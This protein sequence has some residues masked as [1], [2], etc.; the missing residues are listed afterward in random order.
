MHLDICTTQ[1]CAITAAG[2][3]NSLD[4]QVDPCE[5]FYQFACGGFIAKNEIPAGE[6]FISNSF[7]IYEQNSR[8]IREIS[9][10]SLGKAPKPEVGDAAAAGNLKKLHDLFS[11]CM[12]ETALLKAGR[13]PLAD[14]VQ[15]ILDSLP[16]NPSGVDKTAL[17]KTMA[18]MQKSGMGDFVTLFVNP[19]SANPQQN[20]LNMIEGGLGLPEK[21]VYQ[22]RAVLALYQGIIAQMF[23]IVLGD[24]DVG[25]RTEPLMLTD[26][27]QEWLDAAKIVVDFE[28]LLA[29]IGTDIADLRNPL[30]SVN[31]RTL[32]ELSVITPSVDWPLFVNEVLPASVQYNRPIVV[33]GIPYQT[34]LEAILNQTSTK[35]FQY[36]FSWIVIK[37]FGP[38]LADPYNQ[39][40]T[41]LASILTGSSPVKIDRWK[42]CVEVVNDNLGDIAGH[43]FVQQAFKNDSRESFTAIIE[44]LRSNYAATLRALD[45]LDKTTRDAA[46]KKLNA[47]AEIVGWSTALPDVASSKSLE[48]FYMNYTVVPDNFFANMLQGSTFLDEQ[49]FLQLD[50]PVNR[51]SLLDSPQTVDAF[52]SPYTNQILFPAGMLQDPYYHVDNPDYANMGIMGVIAAHEFTHGFDSQGRNYDETGRLR[53]WWTNS[54]EQVFAEKGQCF[55]NQYGN[56]TVDGPGGKPLNVNGLLTLNEN[57]ADNGGLKLSFRMW[58]DRFKSDPSS[59]KYKNF[60]LPGLEKYTPEQL[61]FISYGRLWCQK[62]T[63]ESV[64]LNI[65][66]DTHAPAKWRIN[67]PAQN[68][69]D[70]ANVFKCK[71]GTP[72]NPAK[73]CDLW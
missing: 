62:E 24:E 49:M 64:Q 51:G 72:M 70:F 21:E 63:P 20:A 15:K 50:K 44:S 47:I 71:A 33:S 22:S 19:D 18:L 52:Y 27:K 43:Y 16:D 56:F 59:G 28:T 36:Y 13:K 32:E 40:L 37:E 3:I 65:L 12:D 45:W 48:E 68:L 42:R 69:P 55:V 39:P 5:D 1:Q 54:T 46:L 34:K 38:Y 11:S 26:I 29:S 4:T 6:S 8:L 61:F 2:I 58:L 67:G 31:P 14:E 9:D 73:R 57:I 10:V 7:K 35:A 53:N 41:T 25:N 66:G 23:Q 30:M 17:S 60:K